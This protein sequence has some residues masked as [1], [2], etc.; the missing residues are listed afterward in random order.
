L[1]ALALG[2]LFFSCVGMRASRN[3]IIRVPRNATNQMV[4]DSVE[5]YLGADFASDFRR[6]MNIVGE[7]EHPRHG[8]WQIDKGMTA[9]TAARRL[10]KGG[11]TGIR[12]TILNERT[13]EDIADKVASRLDI[14][15]EDMLAAM[16]DSRLL[17]ELGT[18][19]CN[20]VGYFMADTY[21]FYWSATPEEVIR[22]LKSNYDRF[23][24]SSRIADA[25][26]LHLRPGEVMV[27]AS[28]ADEETARNQEKGMIGLLY[29]NR[30]DRGM[31]LQA[32]PTVKYALGDFSIR[33]IT[34]DMLTTPS[35][36]NTYMHE[37][38]PPGPIRVTSAATVDAILSSRP[39]DYIYMCASEDFSGLHKFATDYETHLQ[40]ARRY[41]EALDRK[42]IK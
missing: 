8:A 42:G 5:K 26:A 21:E 14:S 39:H 7:G 31:K 41:Q 40:N 30:L 27:V 37:G 2:V 16:R 9:I 10:A 25:E 28:I 18:D 19:S 23:W 38:L 34:H 32:D 15:K 29:I 11:Q 24:T 20:V 6:A 13:P 1:L 35:P 4:E 33:R 17:D 22:K 3:A 12:L 36:Y